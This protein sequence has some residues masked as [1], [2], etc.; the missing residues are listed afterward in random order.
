M[1]YNRQTDFETFSL[2]TSSPLS[3]HEGSWIIYNNTHIH[4]ICIDK[5]M[6][7]A[8][9]YCLTLLPHAWQSTWNDPSYFNI[10]R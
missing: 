6:K 8:G 1:D 4:D 3:Y 7:C 9:L 5:E 10:Y 2:Q